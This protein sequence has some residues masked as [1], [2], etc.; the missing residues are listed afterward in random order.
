MHKNVYRK[1]SEFFYLTINDNILYNKQ[2]SKKCYG[3]T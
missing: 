2:A 3:T 1:W